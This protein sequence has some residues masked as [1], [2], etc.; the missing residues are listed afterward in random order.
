MHARPFAPRL[1]QQGS[2]CSLL[3]DGSTLPS[4]SRK[5]GTR[6]APACRS[7]C[8]PAIHRH[9]SARRTAATRFRIRRQ[10]SHETCAPGDFIANE[11]IGTRLLTTRRGKRR[12]L[13]DVTTATGGELQKNF[14]VR[15]RSC[16][17]SARR[18]TKFADAARA[19]RHESAALVPG[20]RGRFRLR[21][22]RIF[23]RR[24]TAVRQRKMQRVRGD[25][26]TR[27]FSSS[28]MPNGLFAKT[29]KRFRRQKRKAA[30]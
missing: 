20:V 26:R 22:W 14:C 29:R 8:S 3:N 10:H 5:P 18:L 19:G 16:L 9:M 21:L 11:L 17:T 23:E 28:K 12:E 7:R 27:R 6:S 24:G 15:E 1:R 30:C 13:G 25:R 2:I 4:A